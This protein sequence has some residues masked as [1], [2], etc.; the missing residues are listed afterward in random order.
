[1]RQWRGSWFRAT[2][3]AYRVEDLLPQRRD[4]DRDLSEGERPLGAFILPPFQRKS[5]WTLDQKA[6]L[7]E[8]FLDELP[9]PAYVVNVDLDP[10]YAHHLWLLDGQQ[11]ITA[12][13]GFIAG[14][15]PVRG[16]RFPG[17]GEGDRRWFLNRP[18][19]CLETGLTDSDRLHEI[20]RRLAYG[21]SPHTSHASGGTG[22]S[23]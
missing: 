1:M 12:V 17:V 19:P 11:R 15:F 13:L 14:E 20:Y 3:R 21:G 2:Q 8:S 7:I 18:F 22:W 4:Q 9:V 5:V 16:I 6:L 23:A 10:P